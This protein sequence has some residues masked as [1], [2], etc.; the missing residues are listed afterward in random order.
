MLMRFAQRP[1]AC[2]LCFK[3][4]SHPTSPNP[5]TPQAGGGNDVG[6]A[7]LMEA[8][9]DVGFTALMAVAF[10]GSQHRDQ[11]SRLQK[12]LYCDIVGLL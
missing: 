2:F 1:R 7:A 4:I 6:F 8:G 9:I 11:A 5:K 3:K 10:S 12:E